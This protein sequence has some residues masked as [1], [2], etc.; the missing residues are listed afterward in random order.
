M[1]RTVCTT[2][3]RWVCTVPAE[4]VGVSGSERETS[5]ANIPVQP[6]TVTEKIA[7]TTCGQ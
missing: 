4:S 5:P 1:N 6:L 2:T 7:I 3:S